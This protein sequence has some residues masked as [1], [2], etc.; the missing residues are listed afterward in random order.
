MNRIVNCLIV[1]SWNRFAATQWQSRLC[2]MESLNRGT[3]EL[4]IVC[5]DI[6]TYVS[7]YT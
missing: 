4:I 5:K 1:E 2:G 3:A 7:T 6:R